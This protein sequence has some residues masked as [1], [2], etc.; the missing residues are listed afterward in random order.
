MGEKEKKSHSNFKID[1]HNI[2][3]PFFIWDEKSTLFTLSNLNSILILEN[4]EFFLKFY[5]YI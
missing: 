1:F 3:Q 5:K 2:L 4:R